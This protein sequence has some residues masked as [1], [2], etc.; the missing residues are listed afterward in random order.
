[1]TRTQ[2]LKKSLTQIGKLAIV[3]AFPFFAQPAPVS[4]TPALPLRQVVAISQEDRFPAADQNRGTFA[5][6][7]STPLNKLLLQWR[8]VH[9]H[10][11]RQYGRNVAVGLVDITGINFKRTARYFSEPFK[12]YGNGQEKQLVLVVAEN[13]PH[14]AHSE[15]KILLDRL[16]LNGIDPYNHNRLLVVASDREP[17]QECAS[18]LPKDTRVEWSIPREVKQGKALKLEV[19]IE[20]KQG[21]ATKELLKDFNLDSEAK[22]AKVDLLASPLNI[23]GLKDYAVKRLE[24]AAPFSLFHKPSTLGERASQTGA[25]PKLLSGSKGS[26]SAE[27]TSGGIDFSTLELRYIAEDSGLFNKSGLKYAFNAVPAPNDK[28]INAGRTAAVQA[29][30][31]FF[32]WLALSPDKFWVNLNPDEPD[33][34]ID[35]QL[36]TTDAGRI[37]LQAD[38]QMKK[39]V[40]R[41]IHPDTALGK[42]FWQQLGKKGSLNCFSFRQWIVPAPASIRE[43]EEGI[44]I[45]NAPLDV[46]MQSQYFKS[47]GLSGFTASCPSSDPSTE[48]HNESV[49]RNLI[50]P[51]IVQAVNTAPEYAELRRVYR[52]RVAAE[53]YRQRSQTHKTTYQELVNDNDVSSWPANPSWSPRQVFDQYVN[54]Y[55]KGEFH[56]AHKWQKGNFI[57]SRFYIYGGVDFTRVFFNNLNSTN[58]QQKW[59]DL[60]QV[61]ETS[62][63]SPVADQHGK[64]WLGGSSTRSDNG[65]WKSV[66]FYFIPGTSRSSS[67]Y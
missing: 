57:Y 2:H 32:V 39:T 56:V 21:E 36:G 47:K 1:M 35:P 14:A 38:L 8:I 12:V 23:S 66:W 60:P 54:S 37:L 31:S 62:M 27:S 55:K 40:A 26:Q 45:Q 22:L 5:E 52:S 10:L 4:S 19:E 25:L 46:K 6:Y 3:V 34:I 33:R 15:E 16:A 44:Y 63:K 28:N 59:G 18:M 67:L 24:Q 61:V 51:R 30:D 7:Y 65:F 29:S 49:F 50:L 20:S 43:E 11:L 17:C 42:Q 53:W 48:A 9:K 13:D 64:I 41:L 58:F